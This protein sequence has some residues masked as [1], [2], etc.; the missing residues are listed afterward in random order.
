MG[1][2]GIDLEHVQDLCSRCASVATLHLIVPMTDYLLCHFRRFHSYFPTPL[3][4]KRPVNVVFD[5][6]GRW[7]LAYEDHD[8]GSDLIDF[9]KAASGI[10]A[11][12]S[13]FKVATEEVEV[14]INHIEH[15]HS[16]L[17]LRRV[18]QTGSLR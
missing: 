2:R 3:P 6:N 5:L 4:A 12:V 13:S 14:Y 16:L 10:I 8:S 18:L 1:I 9:T 11:L 7:R 17:A 15:L